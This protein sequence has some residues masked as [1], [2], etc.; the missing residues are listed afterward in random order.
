[1]GRFWDKRTG[2]RHPA[3]SVTP[4]AAAELRDAL[5]ALGGP[6]G[7]FAVREGTPR[8]RAD[9]VVECRV[10]EMRLTL[11]TSMRLVPAKHEVRVLE[12]RWE[13]SLEH[14]GEQYGRGPGKAVYRQWEFQ[15]GADGR[16][17]KVETFRFDTGLMKNPLQNT[18][19][20]AGWTWR[21]VLFRL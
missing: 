7:L 17:R 3:R 2:T 12:E 15:R 4:G 1:M 11:K 21:G 9:L 6:D 10:S 8:E 5:L 20:R 16:R 13:P 14:S 18:V 19:L